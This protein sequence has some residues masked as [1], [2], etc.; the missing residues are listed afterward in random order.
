MSTQ[1]ELLE[2]ALKVIASSP[3]AYTF[4][5][6]IADIKA[7]LAKPEQEPVGEIYGMINS[8]IKNL[9]QLGWKNSVMPPIGT[10]LYTSPQQY[11]P[12]SDREIT[13][14]WLNT[15][16]GLNDNGGIEFARAVEKRI[17][18]GK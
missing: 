6:I 5:K 8:N 10:K 3:I 1:R 17:T 14:L 13:E 2:R 18:E 12:L 16:I 11:T 4:P 7:E 9:R 15:S